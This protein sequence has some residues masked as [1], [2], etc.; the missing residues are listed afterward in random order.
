MEARSPRLKL[1]M[2]DVGQGESLLLRLPEGQGLVIDGGGFPYSDFDVGGKV[3]LPELLGRGMQRPSALVLTHL[4][5]DH[6]KG[7]KSLA[8]RLEVEEFW[9]GAGTLEDPGFTDLAEV[10]A[11]RGIPVRVLSEG[12]RWAMGGAEFEVLWPPAEAARRSGLS[13]N[14]RSLVLRV[15]LR[16][17]CFLLT[18]DLE[19]E[20]EAAVA[21]AL[22][23]RGCQV[24]KVGHHGSATSTSEAFLKGL[25][26]HWALISAGEGNRYRLP[27]AAVLRRLTESGAR[28]LRTDKM[29]QVEV[30]TDGKELFVRTFIGGPS[31]SHWSA[32]RAGASGSGS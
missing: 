31:P 13:D 11:G 25:R 28:L 4:D 10:L 7:L 1:T 24:L 6:W 22:A 12:R 5:A 15:C 23:G 32:I 18:G 19:A 30:E 16:E 3:V 17:V 8:A 14:D 21:A 29:G 27:H 26:P 2:L 9:V 20:G